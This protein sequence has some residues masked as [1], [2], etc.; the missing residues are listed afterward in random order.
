M[1][2]EQEIA[3]RFVAAMDAATVSRGKRKGM[4]KAKCPA[5]GTDAAIFW[6][7]AMLIINPYK[8][9][10]AQMIFRNEDQQHFGRVCAAAIEY[11]KQHPNDRRPI[12]DR[13]REALEKMGAW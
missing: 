10:I 7:E 13:D 1:S 4:L 9:I 3:E 2:E 12:Q 11:M 8:A 5:M 6:Q